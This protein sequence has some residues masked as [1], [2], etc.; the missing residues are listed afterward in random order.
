MGLRLLL[1]GLVAGLGLD[2]PT[3]QDLERW[4]H[5]G[6]TWLC[7]TLDQWNE[8]APRGDE[9]LCIAAP[10]A[11]ASEPAPSATTPITT[12]QTQSTPTEPNAD[13]EFAAVV[14]DMVDEFAADSTPA[15]T[16]LAHEPAA[17]QAL[18]P[19]PAPVVSPA[20]PAFEPLE[21][22]DDLYPGLAYQLNREGETVRPETAETGSVVAAVPPVDPAPEPAPALA[23]EPADETKT[24][25][26]TSEVPPAVPPVATVAVVATGVK[27]PDPAPAAEPKPAAQ[28]VL[29][30][31][32]RRRLAAAVRLTGEALEAWASFLEGPAI[33]SIQR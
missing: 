13:D 5:S 2:L 12:A 23:S 8:W 26:T 14:D 18:P 1:V 9:T 4:A 6:Q 15:A 7:G 20:T 24:A 28:L 19:A 16:Q 22:G 30:A 31:P 11:P 21:V 32:G 33:V 3:G 10:T 25:R 27:L 17:S 29:L